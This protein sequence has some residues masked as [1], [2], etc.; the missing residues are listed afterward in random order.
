MDRT[1]RNRLIRQFDDCKSWFDA[2]IPIASRVIEGVKQRPLVTA[3]KGRQYG[4]RDTFEISVSQKP[5]ITLLIL[6]KPPK[7]NLRRHDT[8][9]D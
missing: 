2:G 9:D 4:G 3:D 6:G 7:N 5:K 8:D 1:T